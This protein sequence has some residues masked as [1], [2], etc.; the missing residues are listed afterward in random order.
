MKP[1]TSTHAP[2]V[3]LDL[4]ELLVQAMREQERQLAEVRAMVSRANSRNSSA[5]GLYTIRAYANLHGIRL[6]L[7]EAK[8]IGQRASRL[9]RTH[10]VQTGQA[11]DELLGEVHS[12]PVEALDEV[13]GFTQQEPTET[14]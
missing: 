4:L 11:W 12:Y 2:G 8:E 7:S 14:R 9:C 3:L 5:P 6:S 10:G 13:F 1:S